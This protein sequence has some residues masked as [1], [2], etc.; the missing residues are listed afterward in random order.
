[1]FFV[2]DLLEAF[3]E[4]FVLVIGTSF[5]IFFFNNFDYCVLERLTP[6]ALSVSV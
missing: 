1:M 3:K 6:A 4:V 2:R 5:F